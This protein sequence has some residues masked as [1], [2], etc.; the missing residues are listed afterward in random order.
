M[1]QRITLWQPRRSVTSDES[2]TTVVKYSYKN[3]AVRAPYETS[4]AA[5]ANG[6]LAYIPS[7]QSL[8]IR[9]LSEY[10]DQLHVLGPIRLPYHPPTAE[11][12]RDL[13]RE[14]ISAYQSDP[15][16][17]EHEILGTVDPRLWATLV[18]LY[19]GLP[20]HFRTYKIP[21][22]DP[23]LPLLQIIPSNPHFALVTVVEL[24]ACCELNDDT[25]VQLGQLHALTALDASATS[26]TSWGVRTLAKTLV[27]RV[28]S[29]LHSAALSGPWA[30]RMLSFRHCI[31]IDKDVIPSLQLFPLLSVVDLTGTKYT[32][33]VD[34]NT[35][36]RPDGDPKLYHPASLF[37]ALDTLDEISRVCQGVSIYPHPQPFLLH[38][39]S[40]EHRR[41][42]PLRSASMLRAKPGS[43]GRAAYGQHAGPLRQHANDHERIAADEARRHAS[44]AAATVF[45]ASSETSSLPPVL[46]KFGEIYNHTT[47][48]SPANR[49][50]SIA[51]RHP[52]PTADQSSQ[53]LFREPP[54]WAVLETMR[55]E[56]SGE[57]DTNRPRSR[58]SVDEQP[59]SSTA[60][61]TSQRATESVGAVFSMLKS[62]LAIDKTQ[63]A[64]DKTPRTT[65]S[66]VN[67]FSRKMF[68]DAFNLR[69]SQVEQSGL[70]NGPRKM[71]RVSA[72]DSSQDDIEPEIPKSRLPI[73]P[74]STKPT[75]P[76]STLPVPPLPP[77]LKLTIGGPD[78]A[79][80]RK[81]SGTPVRL[82]A[83]TVQTKLNAY[84]K[85]DATRGRTS[86]AGFHLGV[87]GS[88]TDI[89]PVNTGEP[90]EFQAQGW[91][92][93]TKKKRK[94]SDSDSSFDW[95]RWGGT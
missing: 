63:A 2:C 88:A 72:E 13:L 50:K 3:I 44:R 7:L 41:V 78:R 23:Y 89:A 33:P 83:D 93:A 53:R 69:E 36:F 26:L 94:S 68:E 18:Q 27:K 71:R 48:I 67:P 74:R 31:H 95:K 24:P 64:K 77:S 32:R 30:L 45:Y 85:E 57:A 25:I 62:R 47:S 14:L 76:I 70:T 52:N 66:T 43:T 79:M 21:L 81:S 38:V 54:P 15:P 37:N 59:L 61:V 28:D 16:T 56:I 65:K 92:S 34:R 49:A 40:L 4:Q 22:A 12:D 80:L 11:G 91:S 90:S 35:P 17:S 84:L 20:E 8:C 29:S 19:G 46:P 51:A 9:I 10:P 5:S 60:L 39:D 86:S 75:R 1:S 58:I 55:S 82:H 42:S 73:P 87:R 6:P